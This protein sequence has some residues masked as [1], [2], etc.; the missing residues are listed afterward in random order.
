MG[1]RKRRWVGRRGLER[2]TNDDDSAE[3]SID[4]SEESPALR[5]RAEVS[6]SDGRGSGGEKVSC[7]DITPALQRMVDRAAKD[8]I[9]N[10]HATGL[11]EPSLDWPS[12]KG[13]ECRVMCR[14]MFPEWKSGWQ[15]ERKSWCRERGARGAVWLAG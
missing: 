15:D 10:E 14:V 11:A 3:W 7:L 9:G 1:G 6:I 8:V 13:G 12:P 5:R 2:V 4:R